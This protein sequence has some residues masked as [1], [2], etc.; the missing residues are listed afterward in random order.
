MEEIITGLI[1]FAGGS[2]LNFCVTKIYNYITGSSINF[3]WKEHNDVK[4]ITPSISFEELKKRIRIVVIDDEVGFPTKYF[5]AEGYAIDE[6]KNVA[7]QGY[8]KLESGFYDIIVLD[9]KGVAKDFSIE[10]GLGVLESLKENNRSQIVIAYSQ[11]SYDLSKSRFW[12]LADETIHKPSDFLT[13][14]KIIDN[15]INTK[16]KPERY[17]ETL[18]QILES[19]DVSKRKIKKINKELIRTIENKKEIDW[20]KVLGFIEDKTELVNRLINISNTIF[21]FFK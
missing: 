6:W 14:K 16:F 10:D 3:L 13:I 21:K 11:H 1:I 5:R 8:G 15:L 2:L 7:E 9:I 12:K 4:K 19:Y 18:N 20:N 17:I